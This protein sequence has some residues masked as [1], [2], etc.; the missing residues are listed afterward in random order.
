MFQRPQGVSGVARRLVPPPPE[1]LTP[2]T[3][4]SLPGSTCGCH[5]VRQHDAATVSLFGLVGY[6]GKDA[7]EVVWCRLC[8]T[9]RRNVEA[10]LLGVVWSGRSPRV[11]WA[12]PRCTFSPAFWA[13]E[14]QRVIIELPGLSL[15]ADVPCKNATCAR[16]V[17]PGDA[18][19]WHC[20]IANPGKP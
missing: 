10:N 13:P 4:C 3:D 1:I 9:S 2:S 19:C 5:M 6:A 11:A 17:S 14:D 16:P 7:D 8:A 18:K 20:E 15:S 12:D